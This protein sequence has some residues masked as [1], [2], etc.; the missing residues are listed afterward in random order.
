MAD[1]LVDIECQV[2]DLFGEVPMRKP[3]EVHEHSIISGPK[4]NRGEKIVHSHE[5]GDIPH[6]HEHTGP[7]TY[8]IDQD[9]WSRATDGVA[10]GGRKRFTQKPEGEQLPRIELEDWQKGF[11]IHHGPAPPGFEGTGGG[12]LAAARMTL[13]FKMT[14]SNIVPFPCPEK[15]ADTEDAKGRLL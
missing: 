14:V 11:E 12:H 5:G 10:G 15:L 6:K 7:A 9:D 2:I 4:E 1:K 8:T 3:F 13:A